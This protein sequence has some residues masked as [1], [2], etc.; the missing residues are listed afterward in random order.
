VLRNTMAQV[1]L[2]RADERSRALRATVADLLAMDEPRRTIAAMM[3]GLD[4]RYDVGSGHPL[5]GWRM[6]D[7]DLSTAAGRTSVFTLLHAALPVLLHLD[8]A[9][10][11]G[12]DAGALS[13]WADRVRTVHAEPPGPFELPV[14]GSVTAPAVVVVRPDGHVAW[15]GDPADPG[16]PRALAAWFG[17]P[18]PS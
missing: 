17:P 8:G 15:A 9:A 11:P 7:L 2:G 16:L 1:A 12:S 4:I 10:P 6:P 13:P 3:S 18:A 14:V 5:A